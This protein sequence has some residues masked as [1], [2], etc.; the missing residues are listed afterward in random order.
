MKKQYKMVI[1]V[2]SVFF[3]IWIVH[4]LLNFG[5]TGYNQTACKVKDNI[6][7]YNE[8]ILTYEGTIVDRNGRT[9]SFSNK[10]GESGIVELPAYHDLI[11]FSSRQFGSSGIRRRFHDELWQRDKKTDRGK[12]IKLTTDNYIQT[13]IYD[14][15]KGRN[16]A[17]IVLL[18]ETGEILGLCSSREYMLDVNNMTA[19]SMEKA[20]SVEEYY[21]PIYL[22]PTAPGSTMKTLTSIAILEENL[23]DITYN[24]IGV[25]KVNGYNIHNYAMKI[26]GNITMEDA[27]INSVNTYYAHMAV[28][29]I[30]PFKLKDVCE[31]FLLNE[32]IEL[33]FATLKSSHGFK[34]ISKENIAASS[35][36]QGKMNVTPLNMAMVGIGIQS[37]EVKIPHIIDSIDNKPYKVNNSAIFME[38]N[39]TFK[40]SKNQVLKS[41]TEVMKKTAIKYGF[42][43]AMGIAAKSGTAQVDNH[44]EKTRATLLTFNDKFT[45]VVVEDGYKDGGQLVNE[46]INIYK[47]LEKIDLE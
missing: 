25:E 10:K 39:K 33:D 13:V 46:V 15:I 29:Y 31:R 12:E 7:R 36:G 22:K 44:S 19:D 2:F 35:F 45:V 17:G 38:K 1:A 26:Y 5:I 34:D 18:N 24:D 40:T 42:P 3:I 27:L 20:N 16:A 47:A 4:V 21:L 8:E 41:L 23:Q 6:N 43:E 11:G 37:G 14:Q 9:I 30:D 32:T 28:N